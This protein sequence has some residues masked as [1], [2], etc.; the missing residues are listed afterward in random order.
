M[1]W[2]LC[3]DRLIHVAEL[4]HPGTSMMCHLELKFV[5]WG[6]MAASARPQ[7]HL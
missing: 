6:F 7:L 1:P 4:G 3:D 5:C 2:H